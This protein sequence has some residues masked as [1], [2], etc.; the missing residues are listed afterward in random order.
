MSLKLRIRYQFH[1]FFNSIRAFTLP[2]WLTGTSARIIIIGLVIVLGI[3]YIAET[4]SLSTSGYIIHNLESQ[5]SS[6]QN[7]VQKLESEV[8]AN[9][10]LASIKKRL[11]EV[12]MAPVARIKYISTDAAMAKR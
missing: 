2:A 9:Q 8:A 4:N 3:G 5:V 6:A 1:H 12:K 10:S 7:G 11:S